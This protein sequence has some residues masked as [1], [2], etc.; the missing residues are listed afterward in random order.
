MDDP[1]RLR[2]SVRGFLDLDFDTLL[3][4]DGVSLLRAAKLEMKALVDGF[5]G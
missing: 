3:L 4:C 1:A 2:Q 5:P